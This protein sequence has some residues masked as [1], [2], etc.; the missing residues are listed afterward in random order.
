[1]ERIVRRFES[2]NCYDRTKIPNSILKIEKLNFD[3]DK[4]VEVFGFAIST[5]RYVLFRYDSRGN[6]VILD[7][8]AHGLGYLYPPRDTPKD[9]PESDWVLEAWHWI[10]E[11][12]VARPRPKPNWFS[13]PAMMRMTVSTPTTPEVTATTVPTRTAVRTGPLLSSPGSTM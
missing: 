10:L 13:I 11:G 8:K 9:D 7:A 5:K 1:V 4:Q 6:I 3:S 2:L 12:E